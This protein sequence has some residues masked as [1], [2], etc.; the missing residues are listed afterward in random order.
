MRI[1]LLTVNQEAG[2]KILRGSCP[3][4]WAGLALRSEKE[5]GGKQG[6]TLGLFGCLWGSESTRYLAFPSVEEESPRD[7]EL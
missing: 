5:V 4:L 1:D 6:C 7:L 2:F 3:R